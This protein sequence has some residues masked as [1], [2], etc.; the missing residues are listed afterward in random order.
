VHPPIKLDEPHTVITVAWDAETGTAFANL[1]PRHIA[2]PTYL[3]KRDP[4][5]PLSDDW[6]SDYLSTQYG[7]TVLDWQLSTPSETPND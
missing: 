1:P 4:K 2:V 6:V 3:V 7:L 5:N